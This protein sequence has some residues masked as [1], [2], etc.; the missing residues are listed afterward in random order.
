MKWRVEK[1]GGADEGRQPLNM[2]KARPDIWENQ[3]PTSPGFSKVSQHV[4]TCLLAQ[5]PGSLGISLIEPGVWKLSGV[6]DSTSC[7]SSWMLHGL[8]KVGECYKYDRST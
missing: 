2:L 6:P 7:T 1:S 4:T 8:N 3:I 5:G